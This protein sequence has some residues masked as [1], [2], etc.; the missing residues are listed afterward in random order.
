M[1][2][3]QILMF[4][5]IISSIIMVVS[6]GPKILAAVI[7]CVPTTDDCRGTNDSDVMIGTNQKDIMIGD[8]G[9]DKMQ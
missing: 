8:G 6:S 9:D 2:Q 5:L 7:K 1:R 4:L 3:Y